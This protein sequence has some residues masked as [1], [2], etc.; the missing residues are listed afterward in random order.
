[1]HTLRAEPLSIAAAW[2]QARGAGWSVAATTMDTPSRHRERRTRSGDT[3][4]PALDAQ[5]A[6]RR[7]RPEL[8]IAESSATISPAPSARGRQAK[9]PPGPGARLARAYVRTLPV[10][11]VRITLRLK[12]SL[13]RREINTSRL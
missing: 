1:M 8:L 2:R 7:G 10:A 3:P 13:R 5:S 12:R 11:P 9:C 4:P 6:R